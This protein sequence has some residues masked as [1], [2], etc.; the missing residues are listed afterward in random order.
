[1][2]RYRLGA[3]AVACVLVAAALALVAGAFGGGAAQ[4]A[5]AASSASAAGSLTIE[6]L[7]GASALDVQSYTWGVKNP[8]TIGSSGGGAG[9]GKA[10]F[11]DLVVTRPV[12][13]VSPRLV[14]AAATGQ[15][16]AS[17]TL[18][19]PM[20]KG[21][22]RYT[23]DLVIVSGVEHSGSGDVPVETLT[24]TYGTVA[25]EAAS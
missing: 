8:V 11:S 12:D 19:V 10:T 1:M 20:R 23:F 7:Q 9:A 5:Q 21:V 18:E 14:T 17:A 2:I 22:T 3:A 6:G 15:H 24:L 25:V 13:S 16:F 4:A